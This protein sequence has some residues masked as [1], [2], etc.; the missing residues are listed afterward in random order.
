MS[1]LIDRLRKDFP[2]DPRIAGSPE[3]ELRWK[4]ANELEHQST[5]I[6]MLQ[7][8][9]AGYEERQQELTKALEDLVTLKDYKCWHG[10][11]PDYLEKLPIV[12]QQARDA[13]GLD[14]QP[15]I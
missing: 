2:M 11:T 13:L 7:A 1:D 10:K 8:E 12:W 5:S 3:M 6:D 4:A 14:K 9:I 15:R